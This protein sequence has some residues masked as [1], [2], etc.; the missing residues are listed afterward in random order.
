MTDSNE[1]NFLSERSEKTADGLKR[2]E[3]LKQRNDKKD[4]GRRIEKESGSSD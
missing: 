1:V 2:Q 4:R 3:V